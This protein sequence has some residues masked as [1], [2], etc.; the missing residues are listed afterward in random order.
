MKKEDIEKAAQDYDDGLIYSS[1]KDQTDVLKA[2]IA[3][4]EYRINSV[5]HSN[6]ELPIRNIDKYY[7]GEEI[8]I[9][10]IDGKINFGIVYYG[11]GFNGN[12]LYTV[13]CMD[14]TYTMDE[15]RRWAYIKDLTP[16]T[17]E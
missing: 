5:W 14:K 11:Y 1:I 12:M 16:D 17:E 13:T 4:A 3:G 10:T 6:I 9:Q 2:F 15:I 8:L 7:T